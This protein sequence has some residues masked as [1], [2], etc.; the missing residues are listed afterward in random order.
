MLALLNTVM[1]GFRLLK[2]VHEYMNLDP[3]FYFD[4]SRSKNFY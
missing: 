3:N 4:E 1:Q 2:F